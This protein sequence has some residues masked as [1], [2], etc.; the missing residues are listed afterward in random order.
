MIYRLPYG[1]E[2]TTDLLWKLVQKHKTYVAKYARRL[3]DAYENKY[4]ICLNL[5][6]KV[7]NFSVKL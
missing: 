6:I 4:E 2:M 1:T 7:F 3:Q 5:V